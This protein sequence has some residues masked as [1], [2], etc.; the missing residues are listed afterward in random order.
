MNRLTSSYLAN[1]WVRSL[2]VALALFSCLTACKRAHHRERADAEAY[3]LISEKATDPRWSPPD[4]SIELDPR[5]RM[6]DGNDPDH[7]PMPPDDPASNELM[8]RIDGKPNY[9]HWEK[10]GTT[11][12][13]ENPEFMKHLPLDENGLLR[14][15]LATAVDLALLHSPRLPGNI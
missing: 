6:F 1:P 10:Y 12:Y 3:E 4:I 9:P 2:T 5:S 14:L 7:P 13:V 11:P 15:D 8:Y